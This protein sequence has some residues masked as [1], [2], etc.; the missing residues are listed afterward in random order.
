[1]TARGER[2]DLLV[3]V[4]SRDATTRALG[5][6]G[7]SAVYGLSASFGYLFGLTNEGKVLLVNPDNGATQELFRRRD[8]RFWGAANGD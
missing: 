7:A 6:M 1:M 4:D 3:Y 2:N 8:V 5:A